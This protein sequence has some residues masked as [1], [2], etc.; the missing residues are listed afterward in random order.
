[1]VKDVVKKMPLPKAFVTEKLWLA[2]G[3]ETVLILPSL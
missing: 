3:L 1:M 2:E